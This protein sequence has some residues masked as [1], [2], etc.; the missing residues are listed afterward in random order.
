MEGGASR[1]RMRH[2]RP[3]GATTAEAVVNAALALADEVGLEALTIRAVAQRVAAPPMSLYTHFASKEE[4]LDL[5]YA[6]VARR[7]YADAG[8][9]T[10]Q[11][12]FT[13][14]CHQLRALILGHPHWTP[15]L[16]RT[17][18]PLS[19]PVRER[20]LA[21]MTSDGFSPENALHAFTSIVLAAL[22][23]VL[24]ELK[25]REPGG[26]ST[27][28]TRFDRLKTAVASEESGVDEPVTRSAFNVASFDI[29]AVFS[30]TLANVI[31]GL[32]GRRTPRPGG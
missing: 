21:L 7:M 23:L 8:H 26:V 18:R 20:V 24:V 3:R 22:G 4:L 27:L 16:S 14:L 15:L 2:Q 10:W 12:E 5:M 30:F 6:E 17:A 31:A 32:E 19:V 13:S 29:S 25:Y 9:P 11:A 28:A 1:S